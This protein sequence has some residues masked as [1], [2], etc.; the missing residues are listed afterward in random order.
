M[1]KRQIRYGAGICMVNSSLS[2]MK[3]ETYCYC[4]PP[5]VWNALSPVAGNYIGRIIE[6]F[7]RYFSFS[8]FRSVRKSSF[9]RWEWK[10]FFFFFFKFLLHRLDLMDYFF[11][12]FFFFNSKRIKPIVKSFLSPVLSIT[13]IDTIR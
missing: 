4:S 6:K 8:F 7:P 9:H 1:V 12:L 10:F 2:R 11:F 13:I 3:M 5:T